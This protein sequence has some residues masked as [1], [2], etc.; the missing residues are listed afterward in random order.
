MLGVTRGRLRIWTE[1]ADVNG[2]RTGVHVLE[3]NKDKALKMF[4]FLAEWLVST[5]KL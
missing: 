5:T 2:N 3:I 4:D 1:A